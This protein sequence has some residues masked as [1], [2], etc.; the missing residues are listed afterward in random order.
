MSEYKLDLL[1][2]FFFTLLPLCSHLY[3]CACYCHV[4]NS[5]PFKDLRFDDVKFDFLITEEANNLLWITPCSLINCMISHTLASEVVCLPA[6]LY[7]VS[8]WAV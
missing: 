1:C 2:F 7:L 5:R 4:L 8:G 6:C 3:R